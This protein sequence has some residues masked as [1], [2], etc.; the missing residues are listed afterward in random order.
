MNNKEGFLSLFEVE[1]P[2]LAML[3]LKGETDEEKIEKA[4]LEIDQLIDNGV[5]AVIVENYYGNAKHVEE[6]LDYIQKERTDIIYGVNV[7]E[8]DQKGFELAQK[9]GAKFIQ[10]DSVAGH[11]PVED[12]A[13]FHEFITKMREESNVYV[14]GGVRFKYQPY[15]SG[16][17][18]EEDLKIGMTRCDAIVVTGEA[19]GIETDI[20]KIKEFREIVGE[21]FPLIVGAGLTAENCAT[22]LAVTEAAVVGS[23][24]KDTYTDDGDVSPEHT[25]EF[26]DKVK[27]LRKS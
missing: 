8:D 1:K 13:K 7:L 5:D 3:H 26:M 12:D 21:D 23:C 10:L 24:L 19:T 4:K 17:T 22:H 20:N 9:Y 16:R 27:S 25:R 18:L 2:I 14:L 15:L 11:L 6:V